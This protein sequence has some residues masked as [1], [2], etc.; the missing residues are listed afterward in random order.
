M[1][2]QTSEQLF[3]RP[4]LI[5][6]ENDPFAHLIRPEDKINLKH[7]EDRDKAWEEMAPLLGSEDAELLLNPNERG[8][9]VANLCKNTLRCNKQ[10][11]EVRLS[12]T[13][14]NKRLRLWWQSGRKKNAFIPDF[15]HC[16]APGKQRLSDT[17]EINE[18]HP[19]LG[20]RSALAL[21]ER[22]KEVG[23][24]I[25]MTPEIYRK[26]ELGMNKFYKTTEQRTLRQAF[27]LIVAQYFHLGYEI[28]DGKPRPI[29]PDAEKLPT[30]R[31]FQ[32]WHNTVRNVADEAK[33]RQ[34]DREYNLKSREIIGDST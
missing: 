25:R 32:Y 22:K 18:A 21:V 19:K 7:R 17:P 12:K 6:L 14:V 16:G 15:K 31:Q 29:L 11:K 9:R 3:Q 1:P 4:S 33:K 23:I 2:L 8:A 24:G 28:S 30:F 27:D 13:T 10:G 5:V 26:F 20:R 34:G